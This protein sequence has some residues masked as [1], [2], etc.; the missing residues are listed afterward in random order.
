MFTFVA[1]GESFKKKKIVE[2]SLVSSMLFLLLLRPLYL[3]DVG[4]QL[5]YLA[6]F[7][8]IWIQPILFKLW[9]PK[10]W[11]FNKLWNLF[12]VSIA[13]QIGVLPISLFYFHQFPS[14]FI[15]SNLIIIPCLASI[16]IGGI[17]IIILSLLNILPFLFTKAYAFVISTMNNTVSWIAD[18]ENF[19][20]QDISMSFNEMIFWYLIIIFSY[21]FV[22]HKKMK[23]FIYVLITVMILQVNFIYETYRKQA[24]QEIIVFHKNRE[25]ILATKNGNHLQILN[26]ADTLKNSTKR[27]I[28]NYQRSEGIKKN[29]TRN[30]TNLF[31]FKSETILIIDSLGI[32]NVSINSPIVLLQNSPKINLIRLIN[33][34]KPKQIIADGSNY[35]SYI[36][37]WKI[38][39]KNKKTPFHY[40]GENGAYIID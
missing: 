18:Q 22:I 38:T 21:Q 15:L 40:T 7:G 13:A 1:I 28:K 26:V 10:L 19:L 34:L 20:F 35:N 5:S 37:R 12:S 23:Q 36:N 30:T 24:K 29:S 6:V 14:L 8:I 25:N 31:K 2:H 11:L 16:L 27:L 4:F 9:K 17:L 32:Y 39:C 3:F 33:T